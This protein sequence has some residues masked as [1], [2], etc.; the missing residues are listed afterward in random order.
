MRK[1]LLIG[2]AVYLVI[3]LAVA[4]ISPWRPQECLR[5]FPTGEGSH[6]TEEE[7][8]TT[9]AEEELAEVVIECRSIESQRDQWAWFGLAISSWPVLVGLELMDSQVEEASSKCGGDLMPHGELT[10]FRVGF[11]WT[12]PGWV[13]ETQDGPR[14]LGFWLRGY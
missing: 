13:C 9:L 2:L 5:Q 4:V 1:T 14:Y 12:P 8:G 11:Q 10:Q 3:G 7:E 6:L